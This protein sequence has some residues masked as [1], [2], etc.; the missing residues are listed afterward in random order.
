M[1]RIL[2]RWFAL[3][4]LPFCA[5]PDAFA[6]GAGQAHPPGSS[7]TLFERFSAIEEAA[8]RCLVPGTSITGFTKN[9]VAAR[10]EFV[11][12]LAAR[13]VQS[14]EIE[15]D[16]V[17]QEQSA[18]V[19][20]LIG[21]YG[22]DSEIV[23]ELAMEYDDIS[24]WDPQNGPYQ[25][26]ESKF[27]VPQLAEAVKEKLL[28]ASGLNKK[29]GV[30]QDECDSEVAPTLSV[31]HLNS[32]DRVDIMVSSTDA[33]CY[34]HAETRNTVFRSERN[35][36]WTKIIELTGSLGTATEKTHGYRDLVLG[37]PGYC[38]S[39]VYR[40]NGHSYAYACNEA[41]D[42]DEEVHRAC[43]SGPNRIRWCKRR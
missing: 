24:H 26:P 40:W 36:D 31:I 4:L 11:R 39:E 41:D 20:K 9:F 7:G 22:C 32:D 42:A 27:F 18:Q 5:L 8:L 17:R 14:P 10:S 35:G 16:K 1:I 43:L 30:W 34:G 13:N 38:G 12:G 6:Q 15:A 21:E 25:L 3:A 33:V 2:L 37:G 28:I 23:L 19:D 29:A